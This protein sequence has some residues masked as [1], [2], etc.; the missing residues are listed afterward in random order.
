MN[1]WLKRTGLAL[2][3]AVAATA[4]LG[5]AAPAHAN[6]GTDF[7]RWCGD[8]L[9]V[10]QIQVEE[11]PD[12]KFKIMV[13]P[14][15]AS[16]FSPDTYG[17]TANI[18]HAIQGC[19]PGLYGSLADSIWDQLYCHQDWALLKT[20]VDSYASGDTYDLES[21]REPGAKPINH[22]GNQLDIDAEP[23]GQGH[24]YRPDGRDP[25]FEDIAPPNDVA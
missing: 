17:T 16:R 11:W 13:T 5:P 22:C 4:A 20:Q 8:S 7:N 2:A 1:S 6:I 15:H 3:G 12:G 9:D 23:V 21:W 25:G 14:T 18:W 19:V 10:E 24:V